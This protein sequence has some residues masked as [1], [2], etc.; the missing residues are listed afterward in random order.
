M[1]LDFETL[2]EG[3]NGIGRENRGLG[4]LANGTIGNVCLKFK[5]ASD[6]WQSTKKQLVFTGKE[7]KF[8]KKI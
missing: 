4:I 1:E 6:C 2:H 8:V 7:V 3:H 5:R